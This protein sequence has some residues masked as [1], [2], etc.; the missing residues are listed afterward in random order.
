MKHNK[1]NTKMSL[2]MMALLALFQL[3]VTSCKDDDDSG[4]GI[5]KITSVTNTDPENQIEYTKAGT[6]SLLAVRGENL[7]HT[8][9]VYINDQEVWFNPTM[10]TDHSIIVQIPSEGSGFELTAFN[11]SLKDEIRVETSHGT[12][13]YAFKVTA[14][15]PSVSRVAARYPRSAGDV[16]TVT[17]LNLV[18]IERVYV[19]DLSVDEIYAAGTEE[20]GG[21]KVDVTSYEITKKDHQPSTN[22]AYVTNSEMTFVIPQM[23]YSEGTLVIQCASGN[24]YYPFTLFLPAP[25]ITGVNTDMPVFG[26]KL[27]IY[28]SDFIQVD[29]VKIGD[30]VINPEDITIGDAEDEMEIIF[31][32][33]MKPTEGSDPV[34][35]ITTGG[36]NVKA[37]FYD[38]STLLTSFDDD[39]AINNGWSP[40]ATYETADGLNPPYTSDGKYGRISVA[41]EGQQWWG[42]MIYYRKD[43]GENKFPL[44]SFDVIPADATAD[45]VYLAAEV[46]NNGS[47]YNVFD[48]DGFAIASGYIRYMVQPHDGSENIYEQMTGWEEYPTKAIFDGLILADVDGKAPV[49]EW[50]RHVLPLSKFAC[51]AGKSYADIVNTGLSQFRLQSINQGTAKTHVDVCFDNI[52]IFYKKKN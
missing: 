31:K 9:K 11:S 43:W 50:Y 23:P 40:D 2:L 28:G 44:P 29:E 19:T 18:D 36:G 1:F 45:E 26:E 38:Y 35:S 51:Y 17:G 32:D 33:Y 27:V 49:G 10:N 3:V 47:D 12:A 5:P 39:R 22:N 15:Y 20:V 37:R 4:G 42:T 21:N 46:F 52:R 14:P 25:T 13:T 7:N 34:L 48:A 30:K 16:V 41:S 24:V 6:G 8:L